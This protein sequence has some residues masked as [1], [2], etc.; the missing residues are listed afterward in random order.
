ML[1]DSRHREKTFI[2]GKKLS[3]QRKKM[4]EFKKVFRS[5]KKFSEIEKK[6][7]GIEK[8]FF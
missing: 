3:E 1:A 2:I 8:I 5:Q 4:L 6:N 7:Y